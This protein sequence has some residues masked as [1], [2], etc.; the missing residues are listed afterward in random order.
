MDLNRLRSIRFGGKVCCRLRLT[1]IRY[2]ESIGATL[3]KEKKGSIFITPTMIT[4]FRELTERIAEGSQTS[5]SEKSSWF[6]KKSTRGENFWKA[7][8]TNLT[9]FVAGDEATEDPMSIGNGTKPVDVQDPRFDRIVSD[10][11]LNRMASMPNLRAQANT[12]IY[13][14]FPHE[15]MRVSGTHARY[16]PATSDRYAPGRRYDQAPVHA[17]QEY[18]YGRNPPGS[19]FATPEPTN[20]GYAPSFPQ[21]PAPAPATPVETAE[22][23]EEPE[24]KAAPQR[25]ETG[26]SQKSTKE[27]DKKGNFILTCVLNYSCYRE[28]GLVRRMV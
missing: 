1:N 15:T 27:K 5:F 22:P 26:E 10:T 17:I 21:A 19:G 8:E 25:N 13:S 3:Q 14:Q 28:S 4:I 9:K 12:P 16:S 11:N 24:D 18:D 2:C 6:G 23:P 7:L 20:G